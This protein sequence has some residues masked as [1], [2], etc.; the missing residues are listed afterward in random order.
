MLRSSSLPAPLP[1]RE[2]KSRS[3]ASLGLISRATGVVGARPRDVRAVQP[4]V[5]DVG[6]D[7]GRHRLDAE[8]ERRHR[9]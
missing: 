6:V 4:G 8:L 7:A 3:K 2:R 5:A 9:V 1:A